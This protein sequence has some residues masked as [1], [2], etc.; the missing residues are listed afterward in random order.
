MLISAVWLT[1]LLNAR[2]FPVFRIFF[3]YFLKKVS[4]LYN[5]FRGGRAEFA[6]DL[7]LRFNA[8]SSF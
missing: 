5:R 3:I 4:L 8:R 2:R 1:V 7:A 6:R